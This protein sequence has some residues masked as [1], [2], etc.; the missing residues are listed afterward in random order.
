MKTTINIS[1]EQIEKETEKAIC[2]RMGGEYWG[3]GYKDG[4]NVG[5]DCWIPKSLINKD[6]EVPVWFFGKKCDEKAMHYIYFYKS[7][8]TIKNGRVF[9]PIN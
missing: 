9:E 7:N 5:F 8:I 3:G 1:N 2:I 6:N 4:A